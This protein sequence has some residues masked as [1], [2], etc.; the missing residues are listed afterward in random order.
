MVRTRTRKLKKDRPFWPPKYYRGLTH[1]Q[2]LQ[3]RKEIQRFTKKGWKDPKAY[4]GFKTNTIKQTK[5]SGYTK[6]WNSMFPD[7][8]SLKE[9]SQVTGVPEDI[10]EESYNRGMAAWRTGH[11]PGATQQQWGYARVSSLLLLGKTSRTADA[12]LVEKAK[13]R[14]KA[15]RAWFKK[16]EKE[17]PFYEAS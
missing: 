11:R 6:V 2:K 16:M 7:A 10:L 3:R 9:R 1:K 17:S 12:D 8:K 14:S 15:A 13:K 4:T 5:S